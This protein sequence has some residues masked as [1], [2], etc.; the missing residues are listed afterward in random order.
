MPMTITITGN[1][2]AFL[3]IPSPAM[4]FVACPVVDARTI[5]W[6]GPYSLDHFVIP[7]RKP[8]YPD[9]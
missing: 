2:V 6:T 7:L 8:E 3:D 1:A 4:M 5:C 9:V